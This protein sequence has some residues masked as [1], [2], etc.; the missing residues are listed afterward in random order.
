MNFALINNVFRRLGMICKGHAGQKI[1]EN[2]R[3]NFKNL[4][5]Y[6]C[7]FIINELRHLT[8][9]VSFAHLEEQEIMISIF[10]EKRSGLY[11]DHK[12]T[13]QQGFP[14]SPV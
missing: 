14:E 1:K 12:R 13:F 10:G 11:P 8:K 2:E 9:G 5:K 7:P 3:T 4:H 6:S